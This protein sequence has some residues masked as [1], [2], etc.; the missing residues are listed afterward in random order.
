MPSTRDIN[1]RIK[2]V[3]NTRQ[4]TK[5]MEMVAATKMR[6]AQQAVA[7]SREYAATAN[8]LMASASAAGDIIGQPLLA[9]RTVKKVGII[10]FT[11]DRGLAGAMNSNTI[12]RTWEAAG[13]QSAE[14]THITVGKKAEG[15]IRRAG[16]PITASF[17]DLPDTPHYADVLPIAK[18]IIDEFTAENLDKVL[19]TRPRFI[20]T[21][22]NVP[23]TSQLLPAAPPNPDE[24]RHTS[25][26]TVF[27]PS[28]EDVLEAL[29][30]RLIEIQLWQ[31]L[32]ETKATEHSSRMMA[33]RNATTNASD[34]MDELKLSFNQARQAAI[35]TEI[36]E[37]AAAAG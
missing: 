34:L 28:A 32:L 31:A 19:L 30:P 5:A 18:V 25:A 13:E 26:L 29:L 37:I 11:S 16:A 7:R 33:M 10:T 4:I 1:R 15:A 6:R 22:V 2:S 17:T 3:S 24:A 14:V 27:E 8:A 9:E 21:L 36:A 12:R 20:S 23:E 35:T